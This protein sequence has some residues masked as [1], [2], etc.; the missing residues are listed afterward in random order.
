LEQNYRSTQMILEAAGAVVARNAQRKGKHLWTARQGGSKIGY[1][2]A[3]DGE[4]EALFIA[5][6]INKYLRKAGEECGFEGRESV[7]P[8]AAVLYRTNSQSRLVEEAMRRY[9]IGYTMV[10]GFSFY[11]R[12]EIKDMLSYLKLV[13]NVDD[14]IALQRVVNTP[15]RGVGKT[16]M[17]TVERLALETGSSLW[18]ATGR[19]LKERLL[20]QRACLALENF[21]RVIQDARAMLAPGFDEKLAADV[22]AASVG[23]E[24]SDAAEEELQIDAAADFEIAS[25]EAD[26]SFDFAEFDDDGQGLLGL[27]PLG[28][29]LRLDAT[30]FNPFLEV[31]PEPSEMPTPLERAS[32]ARAAAQTLAQLATSEDRAFRKPGDPATL[33]EMIRFLI[34]R[35]GYIRA[36]EEE[37]TPESLSRIENLKE[38]ANAAQDAQARGETLHE[39]LDHAAL[40]SEV[41][42]Y[43]PSS[44]VTLMTLHAAKGLEFPL[45]LL[46][47]MEEGLF[48]HSRTLNSPND[49]EEERRLCYVGMTRAM[50]TLIVTR[51][52]YRRR[53][54]N[55]M[56]EASLPSRFLEE[57]PS[58]LME[59]LSPVRSRT[60]SWSGGGRDWN[61][62]GRSPYGD[63]DMESGRHYSY[64]EEDQ[65]ARLSASSAPGSRYGSG[66]TPKAA[67]K[68]GSGAGS[69]DNI[70]Q[71]F[72]AKGKGGYTPRPKLEIPVASGATG[73]KNGERVRH[74]KYGDGIVFRTEGDGDS[75]KITVQFAKFGVKKLVEKFANLEKV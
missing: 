6:Q 45:V 7:Q 46:A 65:S 17:E 2:E 69:L 49:M 37:A 19:A 61:G 64:E 11:D 40:V 48:P 29:E 67:V 59:D 54:G 47:G 72:T 43:D 53:Y 9:G 60:Q 63:D 58:D 28:E 36:L 12:S 32:H 13:Q 3:P 57:I 41:D 5:D 27:E 30:E 14:S 56:P 70:A 31:I 16:T 8:R 1:Y 74:P 22:S 26:T 62:R 44:R 33:P 51:A 66:F 4:N 24:L 38:L 23:G 25:D 21:R 18:A 39:F 15:P 73:F 55:D 50:D 35:T 34:D 71:F 42:K 20:P 75:A 68:S 10:G 52:R